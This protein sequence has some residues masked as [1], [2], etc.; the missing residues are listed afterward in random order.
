MG[1]HVKILQEIRLISDNLLYWEAVDFVAEF[2]TKNDIPE[3]SQLIGLLEHS[4]QSDDMKRFINRQED[5]DWPDKKKHYK[6]FYSRLSRYL[7]DL[8]NR[9]K[10]ELNL[11]PT[12]LARK[13][14]QKRVNEVYPLLAQEYIKHLVAEALYKR[15]KDTKKR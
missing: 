10:N 12:E 8:R 1:P 7:N 4:G 5:R 14:G 15:N 13:E 3:K 9:T 6:D 11:I 2:A